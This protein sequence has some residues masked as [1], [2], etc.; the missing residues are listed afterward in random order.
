MTTY[1]TMSITI[2]FAMFVVSF[3]SVIV[4]II[5]LFFNRK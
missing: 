5:A 2:A 4:T 1:E 3:L